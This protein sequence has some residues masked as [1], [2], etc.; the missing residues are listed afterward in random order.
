M[1]QCDQ[2]NVE[3][4]PVEKSALSCECPIE[5]S[6]ELW[7]RSF[8]AA[9]REA[10]IDVLKEK[11]RKAWGPVMDKVADATVEA[12]GAHWQA[13]LSQGKA[14]Y[15]LRQNIQKIFESGKK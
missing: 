5:Q 14:Q 13:T 4:C 10:Q 3:C 12:M 9:M 2:K 7:T 6:T 11:I 15:D 8:F 1:S